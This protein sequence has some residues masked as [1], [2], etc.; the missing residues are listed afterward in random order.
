VSDAL[1]ASHAGLRCE[2]EEASNRHQAE[3][4]RLD[5]RIGAIYVDKLNESVETAFHEKVSDPWR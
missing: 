2:H 4:E 5:D 3:Y 1:H